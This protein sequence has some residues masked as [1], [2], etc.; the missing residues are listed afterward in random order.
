MPVSDKYKAIFIHIPKNA[1]T[2]IIKEMG[3]ERS[4]H[5]KPKY[6][7]EN[8]PEEWSSYFKFAVSRNP[9]DRV[10]S[11]YEYAR[12]EESYWHSSDGKAI[13]GKHP[14]YDML[15]NM[16]FEETV[17]LLKK[18]PDKFKHPGWKNQCDFI[19]IENKI[20]IDE[21]YKAE[22]LYK[23][24]EKFN[25]KIPFLNTSRENHDYKQYYSKKTSKI[26][27]DIYKKDIKLFN[28]K[29]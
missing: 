18:S 22:E 13:A 8:F 25:I 10:V 2:S 4:F 24:E 26:I 5:K 17:L 6:Y 15:K 12:I 23:I 16:S 9:W 3:M 29:F 20:I 7:I 27:A 11:C 19:M 14:D 21:V 1:G 28:Y